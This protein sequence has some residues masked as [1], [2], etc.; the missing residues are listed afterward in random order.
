MLV[1]E[2][3]MPS[4]VCQPRLL[5]RGTAE[6]SKRL[7]V[8][9]LAALG[10]WFL[11]VNLSVELQQPQIEQQYRKCCSTIRLYKL[12]KEVEGKKLLACLR[13]PI[14]LEI[15]S[16]FISFHN[17][18]IYINLIVHL[19]VRFIVLFSSFLY[20]FL[21]SLSFVSFSSVSFA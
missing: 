7:L 16:L 4:I 6:I 14:A 18:F 12:I 19:I 13:K 11:Q 3:I 15:T 21:I 2:Q 10:L 5:I 1:V 17:N 9:I 20:S 8:S